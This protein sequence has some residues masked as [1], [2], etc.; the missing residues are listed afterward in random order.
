MQA[1]IMQA[2]IFDV[3]MQ[4]FQTIIAEGSNN[5]PVLV[6]FWSNQCTICQSLLPTLEQLQREHA[7]AFTLAKVDCGTEQQI[8]QHFEIKSV[9]TIYMFVNGQ[10]VDGFAG[11]QTTDVIN[12]F[13]KKHLPDPALALL[14]DA[15]TLFAQGHLVEAKATILQA[16]KLNHEDNQIKLALAQIYLALGEF[17]HAKPILAAIPMADQNMI[18]HSLVSELELA[19]QSSQTPEIAALEERLLFTE[20]KHPIQFQLAIQYHQAKRYKEA[21]NLLYGLLCDDLGYENGDA[22]KTML[23]ILATVDDAVLVS[24]YRRKL[25]SLLY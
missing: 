11:E 16:Q 23:D 9:P 14:T 7:N 10:A 3:T 6:I 19:E 12:G 24:E 4:D 8:V 25:Y 13:I 1:D 20:D 2:D 22:K 18:Y 17:E 21:L 5:K 15:Q